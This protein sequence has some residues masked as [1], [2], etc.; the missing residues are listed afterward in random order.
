MLHGRTA[1]TAPGVPK[2]DQDDLAG[3][4]LDQSGEEAVD[5]HFRGCADVV[6]A[7]VAFGYQL[8]FECV[9]Q[10]GQVG[11]VERIAQFTE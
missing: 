8:F 5:G 7:L 2:V 10:V 4:G 11:F 1:G 3:I 6:A 9:V